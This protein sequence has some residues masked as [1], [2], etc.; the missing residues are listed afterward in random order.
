M[1]EDNPC[2]EEAILTAGSPARVALRRLACAALGVSLP[3][4]ILV[5][6]ALI[7]GLTATAA[8][9][10]A[11]RVMAATG[12]GS[13]APV[14]ALFL[15]LA[16]AAAAALNAA[17]VKLA[18][19]P[20]S[21]LARTAEQVGDG[22]YRARAPLS[23]L[24]D[25]TTSRFVANFNRMLDSVQS[26]HDR[27]QE[28]ALRVLQAEERERERV[29][30]ELYAGAAQT[31]A[32]ILVRLRILERGSGTLEGPL[33]EL[34]EEVVTALED[35]R[36]LA[37]RLR[38]PELDDLGVRPA[39][40]AH[41]RTLTEG[42]AV[43]V[44]FRGSLVESCISRDG[45]LALFRIVQEAITNAVLHSGGRH[46]EVVFQSTLRGLLTEIRDDGRGFDVRD[47]F[48]GTDPNLGVTGMR[49]R[50]VYVGGTF[51]VD[52]APGQGTRVRALIPWT[53]MPPAMA[54][55]ET[56]PGEAV[57][58]PGAIRRPMAV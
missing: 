17:V 53:R 18:F 28:L 38:P 2:R 49:E 40:D 47:L 50:A 29:A 23:P 36:S 19:S 12:S 4:K 16:L 25:R 31:L 57:G 7:A 10:V 58:R 30:Y 33:R 26:A 48:T 42:R 37:R 15:L 20:L 52:S 39:L 13:V 35:I 9:L 5:A 14:L 56:P 11:D 41:A 27:Q 46:V 54:E 32:G 22:E 8:I 34:H 24:A 55:P 43:E 1:F 45:A 6:N 21:L 51:S 3:A 44:R